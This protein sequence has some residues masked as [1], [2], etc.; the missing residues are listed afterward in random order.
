MQASL[1]K[2][3]FIIGLFL[4]LFVG[5]PLHLGLP[6]SKMY[7]ITKIKP[8]TPLTP[9]YYVQL[10]RERAQELFVFGDEDRAYFEL[11]IAQ[12]R[13]A[14]AEYLKSQDLG[15]MSRNQ[16]EL[17][18]WSDIKAANLMAKIQDKIDIKYLRDMQ[19]MNQKRLELL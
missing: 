11:T 8:I 4:V 14:E 19:E 15:M 3:L 6:V 7:L 1:V 16:S 18:L 9:I 13:I 10:I 17:A 5:L 2:V 12:K